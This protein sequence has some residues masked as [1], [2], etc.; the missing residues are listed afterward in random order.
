MI[1]GIDIDVHRSRDADP[2]CRC[3]GTGQRCVNVREDEVGDTRFFRFLE[4]QLECQFAPMMIDSM[5]RHFEFL[6]LTFWRL[7]FICVFVSMLYV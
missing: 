1:G 2:C 5:S 3:D 6:C 4:F 7:L